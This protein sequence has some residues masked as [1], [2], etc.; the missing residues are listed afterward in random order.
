MSDSAI[1]QTSLVVVILR[2]ENAHNADD[3]AS[4]DRALWEAFAT[5][6]ARHHVSTLQ[7]QAVDDRVHTHLADVAFKRSAAVAGRACR[8]YRTTPHNDTAL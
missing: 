1:C 6:R 5:S 3:V 4:T 2:T 8:S 7:Q